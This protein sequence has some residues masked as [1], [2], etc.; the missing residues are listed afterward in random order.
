MTKPVT[1]DRISRLNHWIIALAMIGMLAVGLYLE[2]GGLDR[3]AKRPLLNIHRS[4][5]VLVL[6]FGAWRVAYRIKQGFPPPASTSGP[7]WQERVAKWMHWALLAGIIIM[8]VSGIAMTVF[9]GRA[10][11]VFGWFAI[12]AQ[13]KNDLL[14]SI[15]SNVHG[16]AGKLIALLVIVHL[17][18]AIKHHVVDK[19]ATLH[20]MIRGG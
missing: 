15:G 5:G 4:V 2:F 19:D 9:R 7:A 8:P 14:V 10:V 18:A 3:N 20:R 16:A 6:I 1:Y 11:D 13:A 12:P 17:L